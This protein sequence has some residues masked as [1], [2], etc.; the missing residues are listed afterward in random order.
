MWYF[1]PGGQSHSS[2][3]GRWLFTCCW[4]FMHSL[5]TK[6]YVVQMP[7]CSYN[8]TV[9]KFNSSSSLYKAVIT[10]AIKL[11]LLLIHLKN[12]EQIASE[13]VK[14]S[15]GIQPE[16]HEILKFNL[17]LCDTHVT[18]TVNSIFAC[19]LLSLWQSSLQYETS[20]RRHTADWAWSG[21]GLRSARKLPCLNCSIIKLEE[22]CIKKKS[23][24]YAGQPVWI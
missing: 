19:C 2:F 23:C 6:I 8:I 21:D 13:G 10:H 3:S 1:Y 20:Q 5:T 9:F 12:N 11:P 22:L 4:W 18:V 14:F 16:R 24:F 17:A 15:S 7:A